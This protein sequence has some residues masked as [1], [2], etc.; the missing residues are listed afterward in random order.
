MRHDP[1]SAVQNIRIVA[2]KLKAGYG[3]P[4]AKNYSSLIDALI[5]TILSQNTSDIN[6]RRAFL[7]L[8]ERFPVWNDILEASPALLERTIR[9]GGLAHIK[10]ARI[11]RLL[12][13]VKRERGGISL[14]YLR[15]M[16][17]EPAYQALLSF[18]GVGPKTAACTLL[19]GAGIPIFPVDTHVFRVCSRLGWVGGKE[20]PE[21]F[22][23]RFRHLVPLEYVYSL[24]MNL[25]THGRRICSP[26]D[27]ACPECMIREYCRYYLKM[28]NGGGSICRKRIMNG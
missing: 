1:I 18:E 28:K 17:P 9:A 8:K 20:T 27:P 16:K 3:K 22:Q 24:H 15:R 21:K 10:S 25:I 26:R 12:G 14:E 7:N 19:F 11:R 5:E 4:V 6:S 13:R 23:E 2:Q